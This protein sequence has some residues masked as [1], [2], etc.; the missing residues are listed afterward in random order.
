MEIDIYLPI[1]SPREL[2]KQEQLQEEALV[3]LF[4]L[5]TEEEIKGSK[6]AAIDVVDMH[7]KRHPQDQISLYRCVGRYICISG[8]GRTRTEQN[9]IQF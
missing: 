1:D 2:I 7:S 9:Q 5:G 4:L 8:I 3:G 6:Q